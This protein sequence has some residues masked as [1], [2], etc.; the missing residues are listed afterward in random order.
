MN[1]L[2]RLLA[3][4]Q[5]DRSQA[6]YHKYRELL[7]SFTHN[8]IINTC[9]HYHNTHF[10]LSQSLYLLEFTFLNNHNSAYIVEVHSC[11]DVDVA[12]W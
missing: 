2:A 12:C 5:S 11:E 1:R 7:F 9:I 4:T 8:T 3:A 6:G 10:F